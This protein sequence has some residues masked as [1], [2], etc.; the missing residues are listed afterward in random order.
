M[1][2]MRWLVSEWAG[3]VKD[4]VSPEIFG[5]LNPVCIDRMT[6]ESCDFFDIRSEEGRI[7]KLIRRR[8]DE[9]IPHP[10]QD[11]E[12]SEEQ[13]EY[14]KALEAVVNAKTPEEREEALWVLYIVAP[15]KGVDPE[16]ALANLKEERAPM[17]P[18]PKWDV[19]MS[20]SMRKL[21]D[22]EW[23]RVEDPTIPVFPKLRDKRLKGY[24]SVLERLVRQGKLKGASLYKAVQTAMNDSAK[25]VKQ[26]RAPRI[27]RSQAARLWEIAKIQQWLKEN[28]S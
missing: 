24:A 28:K 27:T 9:V 23:I 12:E 17:V 21:P 1:K 11:L 6:A 5:N 25:L 26:G 15:E 18:K 22:G 7:I 16:D 3:R 4:E 13:E 20:T 19:V 2:H 8:D 10:I 14:R